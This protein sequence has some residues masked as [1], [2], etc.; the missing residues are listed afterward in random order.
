MLQPSEEIKARLSVVDVIKDYI[1]LKQIGT[2]WRAVCPFHHEK[3]PSFV[4]SPEKQIWHCFGCGRGGDIFTFVM[5][6]E[7]VNFAEALRTL[8]K[9]AGVTLQQGDSKLRSQRNRLLEIMELAREFYYQAFLNSPE[10]D[11]ARNYIEARGLTEETISIW[12]IGY[13]FKNWD[14]L[15]KFLKAKGYN[16]NEIFLAGLCVKRN[17]GLGFYDRFRGRIMFPINNVNGDTVAFSA[18]V[19]PENEATDPMGK[20]INSPQTM[21][22]DK[23]GIL[24]GLDQAKHAIKT[25]DLAIIVEG[26]MD[27]ITA[28]QHGFTNIVASSGTALTANQINLIKR[29]TRN[30]ALAFDADQAGELAADRGARTALAEDMDVRVIITPLGK[31]PDECIKNN[32]AEWVSAV[33]QARGL[34]DYYFQKIFAK[35]DLTQPNAKR[36]AASQL[37]PLITSIPNKIEKDFWLK[38]IS[39]KIEVPEYLLREALQPQ[40]QPPR[41][42]QG[43]RQPEKKPV[44][45]TKLSREEMISENFLALILTFPQFIEYGI[46]HLS[47]YQLAGADHQAIYNNLINYYNNINDTSSLQGDF[48]VYADFS[49]WLEAA[50]AKGGLRSHDLLNKLAIIG[51]KDFKDYTN[52]QVKNELLKAVKDISRNYLNHRMKELEKLIAQAEAQQDSATIKS[53]MQEFAAIVAE[54]NNIES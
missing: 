11:G 52:E 36:Q 30:I 17:Q 42:Q 53:L 27:A 34:M 50:N 46:N 21:A 23:S 24:F 7:A 43:D 29:Y 26:Q 4:V 15:L 12:R 28:H 14:S 41:I 49:N 31:D 16:E 32:E 5:E 18:R 2:N 51:E 19:A 47:V 22:Y 39:E 13:S 10:A 33:E 48:N 3:S 37:L 40:A 44:V 6:I 1:Q 45:P 35:L 54:N 8:A 20:Y 38:K 25:K 9:K